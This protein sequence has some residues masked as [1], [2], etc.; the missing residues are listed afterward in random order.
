DLTGASLQQTGLIKARLTKARLRGADLRNAALIST[1]VRGAD[2]E[3]ARVCT[4]Q[5]G[6]FL[7]GAGTNQDEFKGLLKEACA[8]ER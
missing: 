4:E 8:K 1:F 2:L 7:I 6:L 3:G 5:R